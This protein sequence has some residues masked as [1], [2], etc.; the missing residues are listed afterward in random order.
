MDEEVTSVEV[1][2]PAVAAENEWAQVRTLQLSNV[3]H[4]GPFLDTQ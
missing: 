2:V 4:F 3:S 1:L